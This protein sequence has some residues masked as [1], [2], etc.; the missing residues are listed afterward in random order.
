ML[1]QGHMGVTANILQ[2]IYM[3]VNQH[4]NV[5]SVQNDDVMS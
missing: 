1:A 3:Q 4:G 5:L 2:A